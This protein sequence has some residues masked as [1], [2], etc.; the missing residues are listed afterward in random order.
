MTMS[1][2]STATVDESFGGPVP[3]A[4]R[5]GDDFLVIQ[6]AW[7]HERQPGDAGATLTVEGRD[8]QGRLRAGRLELTQGGATSSPGP[9][10]QVRAAQIT[11]PGSDPK[12]AGLAAAAEGHTVVV[13]RFGKRAV[14]ARTADY[15]KVVRAGRGP[16]VAEQA[17][18]GRELSQ[19]SGFAAPEVLTEAADQVSFGILAGQSLHEVGAHAPLEQWTA[20]WQLWGHHWQVLTGLHAPDLA[21]HTPE[22]EVRVLQRWI[23]LA[24]EFG[25]LPPRVLAGLRARA[26]RVCAVLLGGEAQAPVVSHRDLHDK[27]IL[28][29]GASLGLLDFDTAA[30]AE[31]ALDLA[32]LWVHAGLRAD[33][34]LWSHEHAEVAREAIMGL[35]DQLDVEPERFETYAAATRL[36]LACLYAFRPAH[37][38]L[39]LAWADK[40][41]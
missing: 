8:E 15:V 34:H 11:P 22:D 24:E 28:A 41:V 6:R 4:V 33:Q 26:D 17:R 23:G 36:R 1:K 29:D 32:N 30:L 2:T 16:G 20:T 35:A 9:V 27:Q 5:C 38:D 40:V 13:H 31:P 7:P 37:R 3:T 18:R 14:I 21:P 39:A 25:A 12:L 10:W 19:A